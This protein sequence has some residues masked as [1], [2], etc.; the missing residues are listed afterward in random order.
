MAYYK[1]INISS[2]FPFPVGTY[3]LATYLTYL[4]NISDVQSFRFYLKKPGESSFS[5]VMTFPNPSSIGPVSSGCGS[6]M[7]LGEWSMRSCAENHWHIFAP[8]GPP[9][10]HPIGEYSAYVVAI[11]NSGVEGPA[12]AIAKV[13]VSRTTIL[14]PVGAQNLLIPQFRWSI[15][16]G[17]PVDFFWLQVYDEDA[18]II[19]MKSVAYTGGGA[20]E[21]SVIYD[22]PVLS[23]SKTYYTNIWAAGWTLGNYF[24]MGESNPSFTVSASISA[25][26]FSR[27][28]AN[29]PE[30]T[31]TRDLYQ[32]TSG[33]DVKQL[34]ALLVN[35]VNYPADLITGY[36]GR[37][38]RDAVKKFQEKYG[39]KPVSGYFGAITRE[40]LSALISNQ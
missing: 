29:V 19:W 10:S 26:N 36:F 21:G 30:I 40:A 4:A 14:S 15:P 13:T 2:Q 28:L 3:R 34:Q 32:G 27:D 16:S 23:P 17:L 1:G 38:T 25:N 35:E 12:S 39:V 9:S 18:K 8:S 6:E 33:D 20:T 31:I 37:I 5:A 7:R 11:N 24:S 22:G